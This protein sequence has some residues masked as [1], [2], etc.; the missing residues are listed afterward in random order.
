MESKDEYSFLILKMFI[1]EWLTQNFTVTL[2]QNELNVISLR[3]L[4]LKLTKQNGHEISC[5]LSLNTNTLT[6]V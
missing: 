6:P 1:V 2:S 3:L 5:S 4:L